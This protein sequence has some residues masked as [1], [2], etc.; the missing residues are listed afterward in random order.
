MIR[1]DLA[2]GIELHTMYFS[3]HKAMNDFIRH[4]HKFSKFKFT[5]EWK[6]MKKK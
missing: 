2:I 6:E 5:Y 4:L 3:N 1:F